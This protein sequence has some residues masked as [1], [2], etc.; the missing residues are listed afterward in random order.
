[1]ELA[2]SY[3]L[4]RSLVFCLNS[5]T[6]SSRKDLDQGIEIKKIMRSKWTF[7]ISMTNCIPRTFLIE[8]LQF[9]T[10]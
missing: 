10:I 8:E 3:G 9:Y 6:K 7:P 4:M 1:M 2:L 5:P